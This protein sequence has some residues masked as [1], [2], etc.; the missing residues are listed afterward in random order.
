[1]SKVSNET[2]SMYKK[3]YPELT[4]KQL[5]DVLNFVKGE[6]GRLDTVTVGYFVRL[7]YPK[8]TKVF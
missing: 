2:V 8:L 1:M 6:F 3:F 7:K 5:K 4:K